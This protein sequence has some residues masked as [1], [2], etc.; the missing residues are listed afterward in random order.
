MSIP[1]IIHFIWV[2]GNKPD[3][4]KIFVDEVKKISHDYEI[5][6]WTENDINF[7]LISKNSYDMC[8]SMGAKSDILKMEIL[9]R[10]GG[11]YLDYDNLQVKKFDD[12]L[13]YDFFAGSHE[14]APKE[15]WFGVVGAIPNHPIC[16]KYLDD[17]K[18]NIPI[19]K[20]DVDRVMSETGPYYL[21]EIIKKNKWSCNYKIFVG[22]EFYPFDLNYREMVRNFTITDIEH[23]RSF[24]KENTYSI[25]F[26]TCSWQ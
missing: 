10:F 7:E 26:H 9:Y 21:T 4:T 15:I 14:L 11:I 20:E 5:K 17:L 24:Q 23:I 16:K 25:H 3:W 1:K 2:G 13:G 12:L 8:Y 18:I 6:E 19:Q 22:S